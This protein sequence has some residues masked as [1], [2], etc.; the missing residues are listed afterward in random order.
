MDLAK[1][2]F[3]ALTTY[4]KTGAPVSTA[5]WWAMRGEEVVFSTPAGAGKLK[6]LR[7]TAAVTLQP[8][9]RSGVPLPGSTVRQGHARVVDDP[10]ERAEIEAALHAHYGRQWSFAVNLERLAARLRRKPVQPRVGIVVTLDPMPD[11]S[12]RLP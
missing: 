2:P 5:M 8:C 9:S 10:A 11:T 3:V 7:H 4:R 12:Q 6:R 1:H